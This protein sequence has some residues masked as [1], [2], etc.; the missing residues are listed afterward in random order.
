MSRVGKQILTIPKQT[1]VNLADG[2]LTVK[3]PKGVL[4]RP[5][6]TDI[7]AIMIDGDKVSFQPVAENPAAKALWGTYAS[8]VDNMLTGVTEG[9]VK[10]LIIEGVGFKA[11]LKGQELEL[12]LGF[13]HKVVMPVPADL[14]VSVEK[15]VITVSGYNKES[16]GEFAARIRAHKKT[17]PYKGKGIRYEDE[18]VRRKQGKKTVG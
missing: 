15:N 5:F 17:E 10:K 14:E 11:A 12:D 8:H 6:K 7:V 1:E 4:T 2:V 16:V 3:G 18:V 9:Y 13:S